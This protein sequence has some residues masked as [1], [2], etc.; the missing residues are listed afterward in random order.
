[1]HT[2]R[3]YHQQDIDDLKELITQLQDFER[4]IDPQRLEGMKIAHDYLQHLMDTCEKEE[5]KIFVVELDGNIVGMLSVLIEEHKTHRKKTARIAEISDLMIMPAY[6]GRGISKELI[7]EAEK[8][9]KTQNVAVI[10]TAILH[11]QEDLKNHFLRN[12]FGEFEVVL[13]KKI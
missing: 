10:Q 12:G 4:L 3:E 6:R 2:I 13:R 5:G 11:S 8:Y 7:A 9:A 1:M